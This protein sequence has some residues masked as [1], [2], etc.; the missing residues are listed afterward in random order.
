MLS[1][2]PRKVEEGY[3]STWKH[4]I[5]TYH[6]DIFLHAWR[7]EDWETVSKIYPLSNIYYCQDPIK[8]TEFKEGIES[9]ND[10]KSRPL[11]AYDVWGNF[12]QFPMFYSWQKCF[13]FIDI[14]KYDCV[15]RSRYDIG[16]HK[17]IVL[18]NLDL[19][20]VNISNYHWPNSMEC[21]DDNLCI[22]NGEN[23]NILLSDVFDQFI[24][25]S[26]SQGYIE[27]AEKS[28]RNII[29]RKGLG[30]K[31]EKT[32]ELPF[33]LLRDNKLWYDERNK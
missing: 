32:N 3:N 6:P 2:L 26:K 4:V 30:G 25:F 11:E 22:T 15:I 31:I 27:H 21:M 33:N 5:D 10:D 28:W 29:H 14:E 9:P 12:R 23:A 20:K 17:P 7:D 16:S 1:G 13:E 24:E 19:S 8:F 18:E